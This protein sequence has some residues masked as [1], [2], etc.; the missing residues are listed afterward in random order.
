MQAKDKLHPPPTRA[1]QQPGDHGEFL[2]M[3]RALDHDGALAARTPSA[4]Q[5][6]RHEQRALVKEQN[7]GS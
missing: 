5:V 3:S 7:A 1:D 4:T 6:G 2:M